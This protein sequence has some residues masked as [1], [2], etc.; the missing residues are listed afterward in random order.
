V[1]GHNVANRRTRCSRRGSCPSTDC[2]I[3]ARLSA[4]RRKSTGRV[5]IS[6]RTPPGGAPERAEITSWPSTGAAPCPENQARIP[7]PT[8]KVAP[9]ISISIAAAP[10]RLGFPP[11]LERNWTRQAGIGT[12]GYAKL[13]PPL[14]ELVTMKPVAQRDLTRPR[15]RRQGPATIAAFSASVQPRRRGVPNLHS[16]K[17]MP[18]NW[19]IRRFGAK[20]DK[21]LV[22]RQ[23]AIP[24]SWKTPCMANRRA[25]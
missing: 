10:N 17:T 5:A 23:A 12:R 18:I 25:L 8:R 19:Q 21:N 6:T 1:I 9:P 3:A 20:P 16:T 13:T 7:A 11:P 24:N 4:P 14:I 15:A 22:D 2:T